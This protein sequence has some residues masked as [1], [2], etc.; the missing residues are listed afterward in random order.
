MSYPFK[1]W[2]QLLFHGESPSGEG[3]RT[4]CLTSSHKPLHLHLFH[5]WSMQPRSMAKSRKGGITENKMPVLP[6]L[7]SL[8]SRNH[9][10]TIIW[11]QIFCLFFHFGIV[12]SIPRSSQAIAASLPPPPLGRK[13]QSVLWNSGAAHCHGCS[14]ESSRVLARPH[15]VSVRAPG[16]T[17]SFAE[18]WS[19]CPRPL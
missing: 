7:R 11:D 13:R 2:I 16:S 12:T 19:L 9:S 15:S 1:G 10:W 5:S 4:A 6:S 3:T 17:V 8:L 14:A 18:C